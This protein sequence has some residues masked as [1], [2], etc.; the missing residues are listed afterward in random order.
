[1]SIVF[2]AIAPHPPILLP[3]VGSEEDRL[4]VK[5]TITALEELGRKFKEANP[6]FLVISSPH[7]DWG[8]NVPLYFL[9]KD[10]DGE[11]KTLMTNLESPSFYL[12]KGKEAYR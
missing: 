3:S 11:T 10:F 6:D 12:E 4:K 2:A 1:M 9:A 7:P 8:F 5:K